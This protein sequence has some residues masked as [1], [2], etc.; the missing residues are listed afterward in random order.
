MDYSSYTTEELQL[1]LIAIEKEMLRRGLEG[2]FIP[3]E[4]VPVSS[5]LPDSLKVHQ[6]SVNPFSFYNSHRQQYDPFSFRPK[7]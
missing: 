3:S 6:P 7:K 2:R 5:S 4:A 1:M